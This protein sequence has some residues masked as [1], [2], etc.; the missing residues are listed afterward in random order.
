MGR[1]MLAK[2]GDH[3]FLCGKTLAPTLSRPNS[4][5]SHF[6]KEAK[7]ARDVAHGHKQ[8]VYGILE[9]IHL[10]TEREL[11]S[12]TTNVPLLRA[13]WSLLDGLWDILSRTQL[14]PGW[15]WNHKL[16]QPLHLVLHCETHVF[17]EDPTANMPSLI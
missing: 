8:L 17:P 1:N 4:S 10:E 3:G 7:H 6:S 16:S 13:F 15:V 5:A 2:P 11:Q 12:I 9:E 14:G